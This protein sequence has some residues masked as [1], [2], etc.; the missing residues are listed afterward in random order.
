MINFSLSVNKVS[1]SSPP[2]LTFCRGNL[3][4]R[5]LQRGHRGRRPPS[6]RA[7]SCSFMDALALQ[8]S[9]WGARGTLDKSV[10]S[11]STSTPFSSKNLSVRRFF[12]S[13]EVV[14]RGL[15]SHKCMRTAICLRRR[16]CGSLDRSICLSSAASISW[17]P[18]A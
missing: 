17:V 14:K 2:S 6:P 1:P 11:M 15:A 3:C 5:P 18:H 7:S 13:E 4:N 10:C 8:S 12:V 9:K 16:S